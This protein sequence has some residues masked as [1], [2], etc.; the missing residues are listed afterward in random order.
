MRRLAKI[1]VSV[2]ILALVSTLLGGAPPA[3]QAAPPG[4]DGAG[5]PP[6]FRSWGQLF[7]AQTVLD[8][9]A[10]RLRAAGTDKTSGYGNVAVDVTTNSVTLYWKGQPPSIVDA[11]VKDLRGQRIAVSVV[12][13]RYSKAEL[14]AKADL[15]TQDALP[16]T[17]ARVVTVAHRPDSSGVEVGVTGGPSTAAGPGSLAAG[18][19]H[20]RQAQSTGGV[21][22]VA[23][24]PPSLFSREADT[25][26]FWAGALILNGTGA[27]STGF[28]VVDPRFSQQY[29]LTAAHCG[30]RGQV[31]TTGG[32]ITVGTA[33]FP[34]L[35]NDTLFIAATAAGRFYD[36]P[37][38]FQA[39]Q[40]SKPVHGLTFDTVGD[41]VC[42]SGM[43]TG[44]VCNAR[45]DNT[46]IQQCDR[47][48]G[49]VHL[50]GAK[51][52]VNQVV[53]GQGDSGGPI[54][55]LT[56]NDTAGVARGLVHGS[57]G[58]KLSCP[59]PLFGKFGFTSPTRVCS[60]GLTFSELADTLPTFMN[61][62]TG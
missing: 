26:P 16:A 23:A 7:D 6:G 13:A 27:C 55:S 4:V 53:A 62:I 12:P 17:G 32:G 35:P 47:L 30:P 28:G 37:G 42:I 9:A 54:F 45:V 3:A 59:D 43:S 38:I 57:Y 21:T 10:A 39:G 24:D 50:N 29:I 51:S 36:G 18:L 49:C 41:F 46:N 15:V 40:F 11:T 20:V 52:T 1:G 34:S 48:L 14:D 61:L 2:S 5:L 60:T 56:D 22:V 33:S 31:W 8:K 58:Q 19:P 44:A 25:P